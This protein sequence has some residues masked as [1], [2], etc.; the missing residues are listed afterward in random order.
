MVKE[1]L[2][3]WLM[4]AD[5]R[6]LAFAL[7]G[8]IVCCLGCCSWFFGGFVCWFLMWFV[9]FVFDCFVGVLL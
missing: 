2:L 8:E 5:V 3:G 9:L 4:C 1:S 6:V 7:E